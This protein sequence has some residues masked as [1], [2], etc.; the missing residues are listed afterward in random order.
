MKIL[1]SLICGLWAVSLLAATK[2][3]IIYDWRIGEIT[4]FYKSDS[5]TAFVS[6]Q[7]G[8]L[9]LTAMDTTMSGIC[10]A[11]QLIRFR[12]R[13]STW[14]SHGQNV[15]QFHPAT[16]DGCFGTLKKDKEQRLWESEISAIDESQET[17]YEKARQTK[18]EQ[19]WTGSRYN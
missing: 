6:I 3:P 10:K 18:R 8:G 12:I 15:I 17:E 16:G 19:A 14:W 9:H 4:S 1:A 2:E 13:K 11:G 5:Y 7:S